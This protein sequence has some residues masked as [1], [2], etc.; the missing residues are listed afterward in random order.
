LVADHLLSLKGDNMPNNNPN[1]IE[2][3]ENLLAAL[4]DAARE[5]ETL[6]DFDRN[7]DIFTHLDNA[8][9]IAGEILTMIDG[10]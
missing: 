10:R 3:V 8:D 2:R 4:S 1:L 5:A 9:G 6:T 7:A